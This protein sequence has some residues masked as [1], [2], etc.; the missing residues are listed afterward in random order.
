[1][2]IGYLLNNSTNKYPERVA[3][4]YKDF[5]AGAKP[6]NAMPAPT[7][8]EDDPCQLIYTSRTTGNPKGVLLTHRNMLWNFFRTLK[9]FMMFTG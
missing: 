2:N 5:F 6:D 7:V 3:L 1:M 4:I 8:N 9:V